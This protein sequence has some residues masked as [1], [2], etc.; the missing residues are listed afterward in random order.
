MKKTPE[1]P[2]KKQPREKTH[3]KMGF[4]ISSETIERMREYVDQHRNAP[5]RM[6]I[7]SFVR[8]AIEEQL[9]RKVKR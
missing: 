2:K 5:E 4:W 7:N 8:E 6:T 9:V 3:S 1:T